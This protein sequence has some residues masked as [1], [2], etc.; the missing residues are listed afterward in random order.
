MLIE[1]EKKITTFLIR[2]KEQLGWSVKDEK[3]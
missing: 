3:Y 2:K 1:Q